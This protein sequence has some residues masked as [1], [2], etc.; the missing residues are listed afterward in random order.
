MAPLSARSDASPPH[1]FIVSEANLGSRLDQFL[2]GATE[3]SRARLGRWLKNGLVLVNDQPRPASYRV[4]LGDRVSLTVP[5]P[6]PSGLAPEALPL[7]ILYEDQ[8]LILVNKPPGLVVHPAPGHREGTLLNALVHHC[9]DLAEVGDLSR[10][11]LVHR[12][13]KDTSGVLVAAKTAQA[14]AHLVRQFHDREVEKTYVALVWGR[15][16]QRAGT[17]DQQ[18]GRH[19]AARQKMSAHPRRGRPAVTHSARGAGISWPP[20][21]HGVIPQDRAHPP[22]QGALGH[23]RPPCR[24]GRHLRRRRR[25]PQGSPPPREPAPPGHQAASPRQT[26][27]PDPSHERRNHYRG[28]PLAG[29]FSGGIGLLGK[30]AISYDQ[31]LLN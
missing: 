13:D 15:F 21:P 8:D 23:A 9:P 28:G 22:A 3:F 25:P 11:G 14:H 2:A 12:L 4:R 16:D 29:G 26:A 5:P 17:I 27:A 7:D 20:D 6:E 30:F 24:W 19:P 31:S 18:I 10:P 1:L